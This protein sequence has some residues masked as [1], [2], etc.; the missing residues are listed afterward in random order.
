MVHRLTLLTALATLLVSPSLFA[1]PAA[2]QPAPAQRA[3][4]NNRF[5]QLDRNNDGQLARDEV[6][7]RLWKVFDDFDVDT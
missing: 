1:Q 2:G 4:D 6:P 7:E 3:P 5:R